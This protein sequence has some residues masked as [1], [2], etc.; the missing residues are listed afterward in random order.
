MQVAGYPR[1]LQIRDSYLKCLAILRFLDSPWDLKA[2]SWDLELT[3]AQT[4]SLTVKPWELEGLFFLVATMTIRQQTSD[5][6]Y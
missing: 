4:V 6:V 3:A 5:L 1:Q 2:K